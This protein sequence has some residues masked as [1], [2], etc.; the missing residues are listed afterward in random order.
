MV[1]ALTANKKA[2]EIHR[3]YH[4]QALRSFLEDRFVI[5]REA[6]VPGGPRRLFALRPIV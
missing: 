2:H 5:D 1:R 3:D 6:A 4:E